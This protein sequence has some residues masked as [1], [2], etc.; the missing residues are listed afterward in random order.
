MEIKAQKVSTDTD[1]SDCQIRRVEEQK[2]IKKMDIDTLINMFDSYAT[3][4]TYAAG[5]FN[6]ALIATNFTQLK[7]V[8]DLSQSNELGLINIVF[9]LFI[10]GSLLLQLVVGVVLIYIA[11]TTEFMN[12][13]KRDQLIKRNDLVTIMSITISII[14]VFLTIFINI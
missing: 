13:A 11:K 5:F 6:L 4:K 3:K 10:V 14:N 7:H 2:F 12:E 1:D 9:L 8:I